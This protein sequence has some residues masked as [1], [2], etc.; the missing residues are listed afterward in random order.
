MRVLWTENAIDHLANI[1]EYI[2]VQL[3]NLCKAY[4]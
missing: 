1:Y 3:P 2:A 4:D